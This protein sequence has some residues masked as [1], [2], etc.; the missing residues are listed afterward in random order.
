V[1]VA[2][3]RSELVELVVIF[4]RV[5]LKTFPPILLFVAAP[6]FVFMN[7]WFVPLNVPPLRNKLIVVMLSVGV[8]MVEPPLTVKLFRLL[9]TMVIELLATI[10]VLESVTPVP[11][12]TEILRTRKVVLLL[13]LN[14]P[15][16][17]TRSD[18]PTKSTR[19]AFMK[20]DCPVEVTSPPFRLSLPSYVSVNVNRSTV[21]MPTSKPHTPSLVPSG[22]PLK[23]ATSVELGTQLQ[24][25]P[26]EAVDQLAPLLQA[27]E[28]VAIQ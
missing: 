17:N 26:P 4:V 12:V 19:A 16:A 11:A 15:P 18:V 3:K 9:I 5:A 2:R 22:P 1:V 8:V 24:G 27:E 6:P 23:I 7:V 10:E 25:E 14:P 13:A 21:A 28:S 20:E